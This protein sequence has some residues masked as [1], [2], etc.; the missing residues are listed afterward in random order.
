[1]NA[2]LFSYIR[3]H[4][5]QTFLLLCCNSFVAGFYLFHVLYLNFD[6]HIFNLYIVIVEVPFTHTSG[7]IAA[8]VWHIYNSSI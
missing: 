1:M 3:I 2:T 7:L 5:R 4:F 6:L 8:I